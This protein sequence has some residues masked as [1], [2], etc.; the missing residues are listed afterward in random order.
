M[1]ILIKI[2]LT[3]FLVISCKSSPTYNP[4][5]D[6]FDIS[7]KEVI[8]DGC[9]SIPVCSY[10]NLQQK[11]GRFRVFY[12]IPRGERDVVAKGFSYFLDTIKGVKNYSISEKEI[13]SLN[14]E[15]NKYS[16]KFLSQNDDYIKIIKNDLK[17]TL[18]VEMLINQIS[19]NPILFKRNLV[20]W[21]CCN[22]YR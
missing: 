1:R 5:D 2:S 20:Y 6:K 13:K 7:I 9:D 18:K 4:F 3:I 22:Y 19:K 15:L 10:I 14:K 11:T 17:D 8:E 12:Q 16:Y 21:K